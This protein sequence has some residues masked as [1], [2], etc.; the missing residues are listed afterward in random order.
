[1]I[2]PVGIYEH[3]FNKKGK[4]L[5]SQMYHSTKADNMRK[6]GSNVLGE[7]AENDH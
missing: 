4:D 3:K 6:L 7:I 5:H 1:M 2:P